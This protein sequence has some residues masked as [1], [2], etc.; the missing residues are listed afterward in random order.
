MNR[1][2]V[3]RCQNQRP[4]SMG[5]IEIYFNLVQLNEPEWKKNMFHLIIVP[6]QQDFFQFKV[7][8]A[9]IHGVVLCHSISSKRI[10]VVIE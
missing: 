6:F 5:E 9:K 10:N 7:K 2:T 1:E 4:P 3:K 8:I